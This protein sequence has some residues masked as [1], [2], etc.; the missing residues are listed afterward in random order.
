MISPSDP[1]RKTETRPVVVRISALLP[2]GRALFLE[3]AGQNFGSRP[4]APEHPL[5]VP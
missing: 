3:H 5:R 4:E 1:N 2:T